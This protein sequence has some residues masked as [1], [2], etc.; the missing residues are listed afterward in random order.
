MT[1]FPVP[2]YSSSEHPMPEFYGLYAVESGK[3]I[4]LE[5]RDRI[6][7]ELEPGVR[8]LVFDKGV[9][10]LIRKIRLVRLTYVRNIIVD[11]SLFAPGVLKDRSVERNNKW[12][13]RDTDKRSIELRPKPVEGQ[14]EMVYLVPREPLPTGV[15]SVIAE[16]TLSEAM[17][18]KRQTTYG[19]FF[20]SM[21]KALENLERSNDCVDV[22]Y[23]N[24]F[25]KSMKTGGK[26]TPC[27]TREEIARDII[28]EIGKLIEAQK[29]TEA[30]KKL[31]ELDQRYPN[32]TEVGVS[33]ASERSLADYRRIIDQELGRVDKIIQENTFVLEGTVTRKSETEGT[34]AFWDFE[35]K[36]TDGSQYV[37]SCNYTSPLYFKVNGLDIDLFEGYEK[38]KSEYETVKLYISE[39]QREYVSTKCKNS[40]CNGICPSAIVMIPSK[41]P[42]RPPPGL[43]GSKSGL[44]VYR[45]D[46]PLGT[47][48]VKPGAHLYTTSDL[49]E[50]ARQASPADGRVEVT[51]FV[52]AENHVVV[53]L[54]A[55]G[56]TQMA[57][58]FVKT[59]DFDDFRQLD[60]NDAYLEILL[61]S[62]LFNKNGKTDA[63]GTMKRLDTYLLSQPQAQFA[64][65]AML[66][67]LLC[68]DWLF[69]HDTSINDD[70][71][72]RLAE[73][74]VRKA[75]EHFPDTTQ[76]KA[77]ESVLSNMKNLIEPKDKSHLR[78]AANR[79]ESRAEY[80]KALIHLDRLVKLDP[81]DGE[82]KDDYCRVRLKSLQTKK[83]D[84]DQSGSGCNMPKE[85]KVTDAESDQIGKS[86][87]LYYTSLWNAVRRHWALPEYLRTQKLEAVVI[88][89]VQRDGRIMSLQ[90]EKKSG[91]ADFD[92]SVET[93]IRNTD[94]LPPFPEVYTP[95]QVEIALRFR[96]VDSRD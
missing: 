13:L 63:K 28:D 6:E 55:R 23:S 67:Y 36:A 32:L 50:V 21:R 87:R 2:A 5:Y 26:V 88:I 60:G 45:V 27:K 58:F 82:A 61:A 30:D 70:A 93:A 83:S 33:G 47:S 3:L 17:M 41:T 86:R 31:T 39:S 24:G 65:D 79:H 48:H 46:K 35:L 38:L 76:A 72:L 57:D 95:A 90:F 43:T 84:N 53:A 16:P 91:N 14:S 94:P 54:R 42:H 78:K 34:G 85:G 74:Y 52:R 10:E 77:C 64:P 20:V 19:N 73:I 92:R 15:Y 12:E 68:L 8:F 22:A 29:Y 25:E 44:S 9:G 11:L 96:P 80:G 81:K 56:S 1:A 71:I 62:S 75:K 66:D 49:S 7:Q 51:G 40:A 4:E 69:L 59:E 89:V 37:F 18:D